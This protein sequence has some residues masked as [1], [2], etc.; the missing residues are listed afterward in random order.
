[1]DSL[2]GELNA[3]TTKEKV[4]VYA[5]VL[6]DHYEKAMEL[7]TDICFNSVYPEKQINIE[8]N[9]I[10]E[11]MAM[12]RDTPEEQILDDF[13]AQIFGKHPLGGNILGK[14]ESVSSFK[15]KHF[16]KFFERKYQ[17]R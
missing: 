17:Y 11:E 4:F 10:L 8:K 7:L 12:Y 5:S 1:M 13:E 14:Q 9:V 3:Y 6:T 16:L 2:G 15:K